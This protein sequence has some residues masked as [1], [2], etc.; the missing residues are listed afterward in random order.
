ML[1]EQLAGINRATFVVDL[2]ENVPRTSK[3]VEASIRD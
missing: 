1:K 3:S 2:S